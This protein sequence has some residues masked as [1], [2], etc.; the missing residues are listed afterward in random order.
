MKEILK[1]L[2]RDARLSPEQLAVMTGRP[3]EEIRDFIR[4]AE[5][6]RI[7]LG[8]KALVN[9]DKVEVEEKKVWALIE[10]KVQPEK[11]KGFDAI[12][13]RISR[14]PETHSIYLVSGTYDLAIIAVGKSIQ[15]IASFVSQKLAPLENVRSTAT[16][17]LLKKY[18]ESGEILE[19]REG[20]HRLPLSL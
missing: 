7:I 19:G 12:A 15:D 11:E 18:K 3:V 2:E 1:L 4:R 9:W 6:S 10:V 14:Y 5:E 20:E 17:F 8:Y 13:E 16:H